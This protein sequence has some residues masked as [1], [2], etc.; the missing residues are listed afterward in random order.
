MF[1]C[2]IVVLTASVSAALSV[3]S[4]ASAECNIYMDANFKGKEGTV[5]NGDLLRFNA[6]GTKDITLVPTKVREFRDTQ[7]ENQIS[8]VKVTDNCKAVFWNKE[9]AHGAF[10]TMAQ[11]PP[12]FDN[13]ALGVR[14]ECK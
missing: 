6:E 12:E 3:A 10:G 2:S 4:S 11:L 9:G 8:S 1:K 5:Q 14:C 13:P 7:W